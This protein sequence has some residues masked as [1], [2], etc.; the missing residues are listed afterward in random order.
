MWIIESEQNGKM[1]DLTYNEI[2]IETKFMEYF[3]NVFDIKK[4]KKLGGKKKVP[5]TTVI[6]KR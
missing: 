3:G 2:M 6:A 5:K 1:V 4:I